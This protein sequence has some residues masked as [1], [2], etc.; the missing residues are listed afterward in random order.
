VPVDTRF[1]YVGNCLNSILSQ[2]FKDFEVICV[3]DGETPAT[4]ILISYEQKYDCVKN[5]SIEKN[6]PGAARN[7]GLNEAVG[8][9][10]AFCDSDDI[11]PRKALFNLYEKAMSS[12]ADVICG[13]FIEQFDSGNAIFCSVNNLG[14]GFERFFSYISIWNRLYR[15]DFLERN[16]IRFPNKF[17]GEDMLFLSDVFLAKPKVVYTNETVYQWQRHETDKKK[18][19]THSVQ[20]ESFLELTDCWEEFFEKMVAGHK[21]DVQENARAACPYL[22]NRISNIEDYNARQKAFNRLKPL[23]KKMNWEEYPLRFVKLFKIKY[24]NMIWD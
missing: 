1:E 20:L 18:T 9:Y 6:G 17:Q 23:I 21:E 8:E 10:I 3:C 19:L 13:S 2:T 24:E 16:A 14:S 22:L 4:D 5:Y 15:K 11:M 12:H 7:K